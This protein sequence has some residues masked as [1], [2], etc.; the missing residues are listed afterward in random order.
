MSGATSAT[1]ARSIS[2]TQRRWNEEKIMW[3]AWN[4]EAMYRTEQIRR[5]RGLD[6]DHHQPSA[7][8]ARPHRWTRRVRTTDRGVG[9]QQ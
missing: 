4:T 8:R 5:A 1:E 7:R 9:G 2:R 3:D 6:N